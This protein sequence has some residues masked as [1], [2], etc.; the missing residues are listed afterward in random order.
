MMDEVIVVGGGA[1]GMMAAISAGMCGARVTLIEKN[2]K[3]GKKL[4]ITGKGRCNIT[5]ATDINDY[6]GHIISNPRFMHSSFRKFTNL[7]IINLLESHGCRTKIERGG[8]VFPLSDHSSDVIK[9]L[10][11]ILGDTG[12]KVLLHTR[13][14]SLILEKID[15]PLD[16][17]TIASKTS[18]TKKNRCIGVRL[19]DGKEIFADRIVIATGG[20]SYK[21]TGSDGDGYE[22]ARS[23]GHTIEPLL[24]TLVPYNIND[25][26]IK[27]MQGLS[28]RNIAISVRDGTKEIYSGFGEMIFTHFGVSGPLILSSSAY[29]T[30]LLRDGKQLTLSM[31]LKPALSHEELDD[32]I[33]RDF[34]KYANRQLINALGE[35]LP[36][37]IIDE[38]IY[39][40]G[41]E[42][43]KVIHD[44]TKKERA[45]LVHTIKSLEYEIAST[46]G[47]DE[48]IVTMGGVSTRQINPS[49][50]ESKLVD[51]LF[52][53][54]EVIDVDALTGGYN[55]QIA[56]STGY[57]AGW[58]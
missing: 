19:A 24:P 37:K 53:A 20:M 52:F 41:I 23:C 36:T 31:D 22:F 58:V 32:R 5:N 2:E 15:V 8:R 35:L 12:V 21:S 43:R 14:V 10:D 47:I 49:T 27:A 6:Y 29:A 51:G 44:I 34:G 11:R 18:K 28:L 55:L 13:V 45:G 4:F 3:L 48:A 50:M 38:V 30:K 39:R 17:T 25:E 26:R 40:S 46:R 33:L 54:G 57:S 42:S 1:A 56:W 16:E 7:D 9:T